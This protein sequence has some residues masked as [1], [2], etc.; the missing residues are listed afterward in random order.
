VVDLHHV[1]DVGARALRTARRCSTE[2]DRRSIV[3]HSNW[4]AVVFFAEFRPPIAD[5]NGVS[6]G[7]TVNSSP[8]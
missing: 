8:W 5:R 1:G 3:C 6:V 2:D 4:V 7:V